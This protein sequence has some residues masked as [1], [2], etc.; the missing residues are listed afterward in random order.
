[1][2][3]IVEQIKG[4]QNLKNITMYNLQLA[5][6]RAGAKGFVYDV[7]QLP[8]KWEI[9]DALKY[10]KVAGIAFINSAQDEMPSSFNQFQQFDMTLSQSVGQYLDISAM[11]DREIDSIT[12]VNNARQ[13][14]V[15]NSSQ[16]VGVTQSAIVQSSLSTEVYYKLFTGFCEN[17][18][19]YTAGLIKIAWAGKERFAPIIGD[20]GVQF[21][22]DD[23]DLQLDDYAARV[24]EVPEA[25][26]GKGGLDNMVMGAL[27]SGSI[28]FIQA[29]KVINN[30]DFDYA[31]RELERYSMNKEREKSKAE[32]AKMEA[33]A[34]NAEQM[35]DMQLQIQ[36]MK[37]EL[38][39]NKI[40]TE[41]Q[42]EGKNDQRN[43]VTKGNI[44]II[45]TDMKETGN[46]KRARLSKIEKDL[47]NE[48]TEDSTDDSE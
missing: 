15:Q 25:L 9:E 8:D 19:T 11:I 16:A 23:V 4:L 41:K 10:L 6:S 30:R 48:S 13:G 40:R 7:S 34:A 44:D 3:S 35:R 31:L 46:T 39:I 17:I 43:I 20:M 2:V 38:E 32:Q 26:S 27:N 37:G 47:N 1:M 45:K 28:D 33:D 5:M 29:A 36:Q 42:L 12:G 21:L 14:V 18:Y 24:D 22:E